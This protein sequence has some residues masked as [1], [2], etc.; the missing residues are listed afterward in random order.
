MAKAL[1]QTDAERAVPAERAAR[2]A[3]L[4][5][6]Q[7]GFVWRLLRRI[8]VPESDADDAAQQVFIAASQRID[9]IRP[10]SERA[11]LFSTALHV[12]SRARRGRARKREE[13]GVELDEELDP[14]PSLEELLDR[15][16][17]RALLD[18][19][20]EE[21]PLEFRVV[22]VLYEI[23]QLTSAEIAAVV[24]VPTGTVASRLRRAR[25]DFAAR[26]E[27]AEARRK[28]GGKVDV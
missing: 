15:R 25:E 2:L 27:R 28:F 13:L 11:F 7:F 17:A 23:E 9:D 18:G 24:G 26:V 6:E 12:G 4:V 1:A 21:M 20:L 8:G 14:A 3:R 19:I 22:F 16:R 5:Q 10:G